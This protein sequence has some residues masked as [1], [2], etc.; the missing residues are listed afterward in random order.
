MSKPIVVEKKEFEHMLRAVAGDGKAK[1][2]SRCPERDA[3]L[4]LTLYGTAMTATELATLPVRQYLTPK[5][6]IK[7]KS[8]IPA[9]FA[10]NGKERP[11]EWVSKRVCEALD[12]YLAL[13]LR[14]GQGITT[15]AA[16]WRGLDPDSPIF[17]TASGE[18]YAL[19]K[20]TLPSKKIS[21]TSVSLSQH[22]SRLHT[23]CGIVGGSAQSAR[24]TFA[25][26]A[27]RR[28]TAEF[29]LVELAMILGIGVGSARRLAG[30]DP[31]GMADVVRRIGG[32]SYV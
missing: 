23:D 7:I 3:A 30:L 25:V 2:Y 13:R 32:G 28:P 21:I 22:I 9:E 10:F 5:G 31:K 12:A 19:T 17:L 15:K 4:L 16:A 8:E 18:P 20:K 1:G 24:R 6:A 27:A 11:I 14:L 26:M 29:G